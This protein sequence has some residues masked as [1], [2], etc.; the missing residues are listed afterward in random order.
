MEKDNP[1]QYNNITKRK[2]MIRRRP[3]SSM[4]KTTM[5]GRTDNKG[6]ILD[7]PEK[8]LEIQKR[9]QYVAQE[10]EKAR[11]RGEDVTPKIESGG[12]LNIG[13][14]EL[15][16][17][18]LSK[19]LNLNDSTKGLEKMLNLGGLGDLLKNILGGLDVEKLKTILEEYSK[20]NSYD[21]SGKK[22]VVETSVKINQL[23]ENPREWTGL[24]GGGA[25]IVSEKNKGS[26]STGLKYP[27]GKSQSHYEKQASG[28]GGGIGSINKGSGRTGQKIEKIRK[29]FSSVQ[30]EEDLKLKDIIEKEFDYE[31]FS[32]GDK[33][34]EIIVNDLCVEKVDKINYDKDQ[35]MLVI[36]ERLKIPLKE[37]KIGK[38]LDWE[39]RNN[40]LTINLER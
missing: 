18:D 13:G 4:P 12:C 28:L 15:D 10:V 2:T 20:S 19:S 16:L 22:P 32:K 34:Y 26:G 21:K 5:R 3:L 39:Y 33:N 40:I 7:L 24:H 11:E 9:L 38:V 30:L 29:T 6:S 37:Y 35:N 1:E 17:N 14:H 23:G 31:I 36:N 8:L 27:K 25:G